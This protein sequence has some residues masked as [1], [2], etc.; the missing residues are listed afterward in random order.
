M[1]NDALVS[2]E[3]SH[4]T[5]K[6]LNVAGGILGAIIGSFSFFKSRDKRETASLEDA[7]ADLERW[8]N[9]LRG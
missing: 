7:L 6:Q 8:D 1:L 2:S 5:T 4:K 3:R 9:P